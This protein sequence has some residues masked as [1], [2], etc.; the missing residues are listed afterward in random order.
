MKTAVPE[1][2]LT[3]VRR[4]AEKAGMPYQRYIRIALEHAVSGSKP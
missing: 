4:Q 1:A 2:L 3:A